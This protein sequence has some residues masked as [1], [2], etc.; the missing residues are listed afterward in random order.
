MNMEEGFAVKLVPSDPLRAARVP[1]S[2]DK[3]GRIWVVE[4]MDYMPDTAGTGE[5]LPTGKVVIL[6]DKNGDGVMDTS[7]VFLDSL[8]LPRAISLIED[9]ILLPEPPKLCYYQIKNTK[10]V[11]RPLVDSDYA[12]GRNVEHQTNRLFS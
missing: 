3:K 11:N 9:G 2:F 12:A 8:V 6:S 1:L 5:D 7:Q 10:P 4:M